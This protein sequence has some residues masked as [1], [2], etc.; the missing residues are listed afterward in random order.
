MRGSS[1]AATF[2][3]DDLESHGALRVVCVPVGSTP[4]RVFERCLGALRA[5]PRVP[6]AAIPRGGNLHLRST[7][8]SSATSSLPPAATAAFLKNAPDPF[9]NA[10]DHNSARFDFVESGSVLLPSPFLDLQPHRRA[11]A[12]IGICHCPSTPDIAVRKYDAFRISRV[13]FI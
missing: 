9:A 13:S 11:L 10:R 6:L 5:S 1:Q 3:N 4:P 12:V 8:S 7:N 2:W